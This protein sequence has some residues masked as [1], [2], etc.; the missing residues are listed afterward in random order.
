MFTNYDPIYLIETFDWLSVK[1][2]PDEFA[3][4]ICGEML[5]TI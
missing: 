3:L 2:T 4:S 5:T 1:L